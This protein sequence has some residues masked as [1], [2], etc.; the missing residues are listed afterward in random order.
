M[1]ADAIAAFSKA[2]TA[3]VEPR[4]M[5]NVGHVY[6]SMGNRDE[7]RRVLA[8]LIDMSKTRYVTPY[9]MAVVSVGLGEHDQAIRWLEEAYRD[10]YV[11]MAW[12]KVE[13]KFDVLRSDA[14]FQDLL[15][16]VGLPQ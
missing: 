7:A 3:A 6:A 12:L 16:R 4:N 8:E 10:R 1:Y 15:R 11:A 14:R 13:P 2:G 5:G 9:A